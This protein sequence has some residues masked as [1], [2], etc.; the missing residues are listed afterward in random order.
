[1]LNAD[2]KGTEF[3]LLLFCLTFYLPVS[4]FSPLFAKIYRILTF[5]FY[6]TLDNYREMYYND[7]VDDNYTVFCISCYDDITEF[8]K[9]QA[10]FLKKTIF[11]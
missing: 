5:Y 3:W 2:K 8:C 11:V 9:S 7:I 10:F 4:G 6:K 1:M